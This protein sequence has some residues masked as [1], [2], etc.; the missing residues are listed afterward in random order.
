M[1]LSH[2]HE[3]VEAWYLG[4]DF[5]ERVRR[6]SV[7]TWTS[8][9]RRRPSA[10]G[11]RTSRPRPTC[12]ATTRAS[13]RIGDSAA[14]ADHLPARP[15]TWPSRASSIR[16]ARRSPVRADF[17]TLDNPF[18]WSVNLDEIG[19][20]PA[21]G[22]HFVVFNPTG[23]DFRR[24]RRASHR[25]RSS[26]ARGKIA[27]TPRDRNQGFNSILFDDA[28][29]ELP[30]APRGATAA[31]RWPRSTSRNDSLRESVSFKPRPSSRR[32]SWPRR[33][34]R[35]GLSSAPRSPRRAARRSPSSPRSAA[36]W[37]NCP[38]RRGR[39]P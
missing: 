24:N 13:G 7:P 27:F 3:D 22:V 35:V 5:D 28:P 15:G 6:P 31:S 1:H 11:R 12:T 30:R 38:R 36:I 16:R 18:M 10:R 20:L 29:P 2:I 21:A 39:P 4:F 17:D 26:P 23:D 34:T 37:P 19:E 33:T 8:S 25:R 32:R 9:R 14:I